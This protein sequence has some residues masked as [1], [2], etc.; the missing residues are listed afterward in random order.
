M[1][2]S[3]GQN[4]VHPA[5]G[6][7]EIVDVEHQELVEGFKHY[8]VIEFVG[9]KLTMRI[10]VRRTDDVGVREVMS[11]SR[12]DRVMDTLR[13]IPGQLPKNF[14]K[15]RKKVEEMIQSGYPTTIAEA[16]RELTWRKRDAHL[17]KSDTEL[18][19]QGRDMLVTEIALATDKELS[20]VRKE[21]D[22]ALAE[23]VQA[24]RAALKNEQDD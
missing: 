23:A 17:T 12:F 18:L 7:G 13:A 11:K 16:I 24:K 5:H 9:K 10:P 6:A 19:S 2:F 20:Q 22:Q 21:I 4:V 1:Q 8:Y 15:R 14:K 3:V